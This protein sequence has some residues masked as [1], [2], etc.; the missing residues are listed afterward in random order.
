VS[1]DSAVLIQDSSFDETAGTYSA[2]DFTLC[3]EFGNVFVG[4]KVIAT[5]DDT[6]LDGDTF[7]NNAAQANDA[8]LD[9]SPFT[10]AAPVG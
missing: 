2:R 7:A 6:V 3:D 9:A 8:I 4:L 1:T 5:H 10:Y